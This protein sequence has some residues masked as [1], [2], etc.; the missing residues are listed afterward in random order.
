MNDP[1]LQDAFMTALN[2]AYQMED[3]NM[4]SDFWQG[5]LRVLYQIY[6]HQDTENN[7][8]ALSAAIHVSRSRITSALESLKK[9][10]YVQTQ[11]S[12]IDGRRVIVTLTREGAAYIEA[13]QQSARK[14]LGRLLEGLGDKN[15]TEF[16]RL[17][18]IS[19]DIMEGRK[20]R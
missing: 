4:L 12:P 1:N 19:V 3:L 9:K 17:I 2:R 11:G 7:P 16:T 5:S 18:N 15:I 13:K 8:A 6:Q 20:K 10:G 14:Y